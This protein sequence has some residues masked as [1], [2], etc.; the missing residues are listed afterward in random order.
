LVAAVFFAVMPGIVWLSSLAMI[1]T[2]LIFVLCFSLF[3]FFRWTKTNRKQDLTVSVVA[4][5]LGVAVKYQILVVVPLIML[6]AV[7]VLGQKIDFRSHISF[8]LRSRWVIL[9]VV[10]AA[11]A[12]ILLYA[13]YASGLLS[14]W[15]YTIQVGGEVH[16]EYSNRFFA[17]IFYLIEMV[18]PYSDQH[19]VS[20]LLYCL[21]LAGLAFF[22]YRRKPEDKFLLA[23]FFVTFALFTVIPNRNWRFITLLF[24][25]LAVSAAEFTGAV[26]RR[27]QSIWQSTQ[28]S[29]SKKRL[30]K[31]AAAVL[32]V[33][34]LVSVGYSCTD[35][36]GWAA[37]EHLDIPVE[38]AAAYV[39]ANPL[40][41]K[42]VIVLCQVNLFNRDMVWFYLN[43]D[44]PSQVHVYAYPALAVDA[45]KPDFNVEAFINYCQTNG[46][47]YILLYEYGGS[48]GYFNSDLTEQA[49]FDMLVQTQRFSLQ[50]TVGEAP[51]RVYIFAFR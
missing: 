17:P 4:F 22:V 45:Y 41:N 42:S 37:K 29:T 16:A 39:A 14:V 12:G 49:I 5:V 34:V 8:F 30:A 2:M 35:A 44:G 50:A 27:A 32:A 24:P 51:N 38:Q 23:W 36:Y 3:Y 11:V 48:A 47:G 19:P 28:S 6:V 9:G 20:L 15:L 40:D 31:I 1:E 46:T 13:F 18:W 21:G 26:Y 7:L 10:F 33:S 43:R 25:V